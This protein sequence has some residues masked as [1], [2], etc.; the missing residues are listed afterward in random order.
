MGAG[1]DWG[2]KT[3]LRNERFWLGAE[4]DGRLYQYTGLGTFRTALAAAEACRERGARIYRQFDCVAHGVVYGVSAPE[5]VAEATGNPAPLG[6]LTA[7]L[8]RGKIP[9]DRA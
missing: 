7:L 1:V 6:L 3:T 5:L 4:A 8:S 9:S 2:M